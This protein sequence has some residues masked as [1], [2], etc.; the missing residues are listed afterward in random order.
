MPLIFKKNLIHPES[1][2]AVWENTEENGFFESNLDLRPREK[3]ALKQ[4]KEFRQKEWLCSRMLVKQLLPDHDQDYMLHKDHF[5]KPFLENSPWFLSLSHSRN[6]AAIIL[7][8]TIAGIDIQHEEEKINKLFPKFISAKEIEH[9]D[10]DHLSESRHIFWSGKEAM[11]KAYGRKSL[12]FNKHMHIYPFQYYRDQLELKGWVRKNNT[13]Q[14]YDIYCDKI[15]DYFLVYAVL[16][17]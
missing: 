15:D 14:D 17:G 8:K 12:D 7:S 9:L 6:R 4:M 13:S 2:I 5:G 16:E 11:Y 3:L 10:P 1:Y